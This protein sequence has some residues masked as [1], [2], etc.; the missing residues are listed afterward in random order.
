LAAIDAIL[1]TLIQQDGDELKLTAGQAPALFRKGERLRV[2][3]P[4]FDEALKQSLVG[5]LLT[6][7]RLEQLSAGATVSFSYSSDDLGTFAVKIRGSGGRSLHFSR[8]ADVSSPEP[9]VVVL[10]LP[11]AAPRTPEPPPVVPRGDLDPRLTELLDIA[12]E[13]RASDLHLAQGELAVTRIAGGLSALGELGLIDTQAVLGSL[14]TP[15]IRRG[16][17][18]GDAE[19]IGLNYAGNRLRINLYRCEQG[20]AA[21]IRVLRRR[22]PPLKRLGLP[23]ELHR[24]SDLHHGLILLCGPTGSGKSTTMAAIAQD[25]LRRRGGMLITLEDPIEYAFHADGPTSLV[26]QREIGRHVRDFGAGLRAALREDPDILLVGEMRD[27]ESI[28]LALTA[29]ETGHLVLAS[30]HSRSSAGAIERMVDVYAPERQNQIRVQ[31]AESLQAIISQRLI[32]R[33]TGSGRIAA[34]E[35]LRN[36]H[37]VRSLIRD[38]KTAQLASAIQSGGEDGMIPLERY[39]RDLVRGGHITPETARATANDLVSLRSYTDG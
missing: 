37:R 39:L 17:D 14:I 30:L 16:L 11:E 2:F 12:L 15:E 24:V 20:L 8:G 35:I 9:E 5:D 33:A 19:D 26:R 22:P 3:F 7:E 31:I 13:K 38:G 25:I 4:P 34:V 21:A 29:A 1:Q 10:P 36:T 28:S 27:T 32:P 18:A 6:A 23:P